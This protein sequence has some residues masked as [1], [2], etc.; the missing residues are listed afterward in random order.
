M[1]FDNPL[2]FPD[3]SSLLFAILN[4]LVVLA[5][6]FIIFFIIYGG[7]LYVTARGNP[8]QIKKAGQ[9]IM[10]GVIGGVVIIGASWIGQVVQGTV[11]AFK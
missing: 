3:L 5:T 2:T 6:P 8:E 7:F 4:I 9:A 10:Y 1:A 11:A